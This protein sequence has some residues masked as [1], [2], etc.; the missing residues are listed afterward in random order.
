MAELFIELFSEEIPAKL[1][2]DARKK[3]KDIVNEKLQ[4]KEI[5]F[6]TSRSFSTPTRLAI[7]IDGIPEK[8]ELKKKNYKRTKN[9]R[10][11]VS[12]R[13]FYSIKQFN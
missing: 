1:Q 11:S 10:S 2:I 12:I 4:K 9:Y 5:V 3:L 6:K 8:I 7:V 13:W